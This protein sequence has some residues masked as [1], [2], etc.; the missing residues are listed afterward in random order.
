MYFHS[1]IDPVRIKTGNENLQK[2]TFQEVLQF[3]IDLSAQVRKFTVTF[4]EEAW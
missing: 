4:A 2:D 1:D 3:Q